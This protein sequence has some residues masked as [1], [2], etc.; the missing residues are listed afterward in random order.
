MNRCFILMRQPYQFTDQWR[1]S[2]EE[3]ADLSF[4]CALGESVK[5]GEMPFRGFQK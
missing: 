4:L 1:T 3:A 5:L 2:L